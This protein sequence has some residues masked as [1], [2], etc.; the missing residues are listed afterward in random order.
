MRL[1]REHKQETT[2][3]QSIQMLWPTVVSLRSAKPAGICGQTP[4]VSYNR[5]DFSK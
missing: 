1:N 2:L 4:F 3:G 5:T